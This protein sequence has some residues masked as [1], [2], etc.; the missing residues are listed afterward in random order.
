MSV[1]QHLVKWLLGLAP[2][3][4]WTTDAERACLARHAAGRRR[5]VEVGVW[6]GGTTRHLRA[7]MSP[8]ATLYAVDPFPKGRLGF[9]IPRFV[10]RRE[11]GQVRKGRVVWLRETGEAAAK[12][13]IMRAPPTIDFVFVDNAQTYEGLRAEWEAW[14]PVLAAGGVIALHDAR[15]GAEGLPEQTSEI[16][17]RDVIRRD[18]RFTIVDEVDTLMVLEKRPA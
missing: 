10:A 14:T 7:A 5:L 4:I 8:D 3:E 13:E 2:A 12:M 1:L 18:A 15:P 17:A 16:Y 9:S 6:H 11:V